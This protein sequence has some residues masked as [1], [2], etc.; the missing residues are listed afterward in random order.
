MWLRGWGPFGFCS[1]VVDYIPN[2]DLSP[3]TMWKD[4]EEEKKDLINKKVERKPHY[5]VERQNNFN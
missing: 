4:K 5:S 1:L 3:S 2:P